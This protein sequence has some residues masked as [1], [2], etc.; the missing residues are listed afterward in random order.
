[1]GQWDTFTN[2]T[3]FFRVP[4]L[5]LALSF[6]FLTTKRKSCMCG[7]VHL[8]YSQYTQLPPEVSGCFLD[9]AMT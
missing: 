2:G 3:T 6:F 8:L 9:N 5:S 4:S 1:M 7:N